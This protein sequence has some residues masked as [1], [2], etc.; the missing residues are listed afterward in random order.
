[1]LGF[2]RPI[3]VLDESKECLTFSVSCETTIFSKLMDIRKMLGNIQKLLFLTL[4]QSYGMCVRSKSHY[5]FLL[6]ETSVKLTCIFFSWIFLL[7]DFC[8]LSSYVTSHI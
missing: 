8:S 1:M 5:R 7:I 3:G 6:I 2:T 4:R